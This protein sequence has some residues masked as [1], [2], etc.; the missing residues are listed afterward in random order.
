MQMYGRMRYC[1]DF[2]T[3]MQTMDMAEFMFFLGDAGL[4]GAKLT[5]REARGIFVQV[6]DTTCDIVRCGVV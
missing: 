2:R 5:N 1:I 6:G 4:L 3:D